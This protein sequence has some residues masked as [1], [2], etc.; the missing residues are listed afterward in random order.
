MKRFVGSMVVVLL[1]LATLV[2]PVS[3]APGDIPSRTPTHT[4]YSTSILYPRVRYA[5]GC[6]DLTTFER[7]V[8]PVWMIAWSLTDM[9]GKRVAASFNAY[10]EMGNL[11]VSASAGPVNETRVAQRYAEP[12]G[13]GTLLYITPKV[14]GVFRLGWAHWGSKD[15]CA[16]F[17]DGTFNFTLPIILKN[18]RARYALATDFAGPGPALGTSNGGLAVARTFTRSSKGY[19]FAVFRPGA[20]GAAKVT[21]PKGKVR[22]DSVAKI[23]D[24]LIAEKTSGTWKYE[25]TAQKT[26]DGGPILWVM[27]LPA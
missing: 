18:T 27:E 26:D 20:T 14:K 21:D 25:L 4:G 22:Y 8:A 23:G 15:W 1:A 17:E 9:K 13:F 12:G 5:I 10:D 6:V 2:G 24:G 19:V 7:N 3:A 11:Y 16:V